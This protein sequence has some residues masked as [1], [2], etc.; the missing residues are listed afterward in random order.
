MIRIIT[1]SE[2]FQKYC[3]INW[4]KM[5]DTVMPII[6]SVIT[7]L[8][9]TFRIAVASILFPDFSEVNLTKAAGK[10]ITVN[11]ENVDERKFKI[12]SVPISVWDSAF[13]FVAIM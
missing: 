1:N 9:I 12:D 11:N 8:S 7:V 4:D 5:I 6:D 13:V 2:L 3:D 10:A